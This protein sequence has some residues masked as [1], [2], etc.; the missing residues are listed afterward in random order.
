MRDAD[1]DRL[2]DDLMRRAYW[3]LLK[4]Q[5]RFE[6]DDFRVATFAAAELA[7]MARLEQNGMINPP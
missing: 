6:I 5:D 1:W 2:R 4:V 3:R 7:I